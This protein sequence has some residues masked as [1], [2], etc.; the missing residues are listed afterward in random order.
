MSQK[1]NIC[2]CLL[3]QSLNIAFLYTRFTEVLRYSDTH[4]KRLYGITCSLSSDI[5]CKC[6][7]LTAN[8][9]GGFLNSC[10]QMLG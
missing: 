2:Y 1:T 9:I 10:W 8:R 4:G 7:S 3:R 5:L 6:H